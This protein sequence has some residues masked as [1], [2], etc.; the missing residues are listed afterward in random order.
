MY[1]RKPEPNLLFTIMFRKIADIET[2]K[3]A[4]ILKG[5]QM[6]LQGVGERPGK[7]KEKNGMRRKYE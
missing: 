7:N 2:S 6:P 4:P 3:V 5:N 1:I